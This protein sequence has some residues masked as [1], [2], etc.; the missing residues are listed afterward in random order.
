MIIGTIRSNAARVR[1]KLL[2]SGG[3][4][5][6]VEAVIDTGFT[7]MLTL[8]SAVIAA[9]GLRFRA[10]DQAMLADGSTCFFRTFQ[11]KVNWDGKIR[12]ILVAEAN[13]DPLL[14]M[15]LLR[16]HELKVQVR[17]RGKVTIRRLHSK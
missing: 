6:E 1:M 13:A 12:T 7:G 3:R 2:G 9:M 10:M 4:E 11:G 15:K 8:P 5:Q 17:N 14:G 16:G